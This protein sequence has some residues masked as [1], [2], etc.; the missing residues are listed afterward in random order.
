MQRHALKAQR[1]RAF[2]AQGLPKFANAG[3]ERVEPLQIRRAANDGAHDS[4]HL[5]GGLARMGHQD[6]AHAGL[7]TVRREAAQ[8]G[9][10]LAQRR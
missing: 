3:E 1:R 9:G 7:A 4:L 2:P 8:V 5:S 6:I 10:D